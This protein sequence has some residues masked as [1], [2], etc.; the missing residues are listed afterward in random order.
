MWL[1]SLQLFRLQCTGSYGIQPILP[2]MC[3]KFRGN[4]RPTLPIQRAA[5]SLY[6]RPKDLD[7][8]ER[9][10]PDVAELILLFVSHYTNNEY[11][12]HQV[13]IFDPYASTTICR[14]KGGADLLTYAFQTTKK[15]MLAGHCLNWPISMK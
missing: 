3:K 13:S 12:Q 10:E 4:L 2:I 15:A 1:N 6:E 8:N 7:F 9:Q 5:V 11:E 14:V